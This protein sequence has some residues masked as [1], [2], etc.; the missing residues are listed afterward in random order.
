MIFAASRSVP[1]MAFIA[2]VVTGVWCDDVGVWDAQGRNHVHKI[3][4]GS[5]MSQL[6]SNFCF[7]RKIK[8]EEKSEDVFCTFFHFV[9]LQVHSAPPSLSLLLLVC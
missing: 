8:S 2:H 7:P 9:F 6:M 5:N 3:V 4:A 1:Y